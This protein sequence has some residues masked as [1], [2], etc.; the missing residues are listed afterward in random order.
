MQA[1]L[2]GRYARSIETLS[3][4]ADHEGHVLEREFAR[5]AS[6][7]LG[8]LGPLLRDDPDAPTWVARAKA[9]QQRIEGTAS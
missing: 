5:L 4:W 2:D 8:R 7:V 3:A 9:L 1:V 6:S